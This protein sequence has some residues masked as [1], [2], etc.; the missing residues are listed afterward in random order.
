MCSYLYELSVHIRV[1][2]FRAGFVNDFIE[3]VKKKIVIVETKTSVRDKTMA[4]FKPFVVLGTFCVL[5]S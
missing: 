1:S 4:E 2:V 5:V 3:Q